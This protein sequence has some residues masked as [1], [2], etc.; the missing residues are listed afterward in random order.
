MGGHTKAEARKIVAETKAEVKAEIVAKITA[1]TAKMTPLEVSAA[2]IE[3]YVKPEIRKDPNIL[4][5]ARRPKTRDIRETVYYYACD[6]IDDDAATKATFDALLNQG[7]SKNSAELDIF[8][9]LLGRVFEVAMGDPDRWPTVLEL[10]RNGGPESSICDIFPELDWLEDP[11]ELQ[12]PDGSPVVSWIKISTDER[13]E[14][15]I[16]VQHLDESEDRQKK[17][18]KH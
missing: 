8:Y 1:D 11:A 13:G 15:S 3:E 12:F 14:P 17:S 16:E 6:L 2:L 7:S 4:I 10:L 5:D 18:L 9:A